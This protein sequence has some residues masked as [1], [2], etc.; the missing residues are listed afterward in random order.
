MGLLTRLLA[1]DDGGSTKGPLDDFWYKAVTGGTSSTGLPITP[2]VAMEVSAVFACVKVL[3]ETMGMLP[4]IVYER[5]GETS[6][7]RAVDDP[8][9]AL[10]HRAPNAWQTP[11]EFKENL[12]AWAALHGNGYALKVFGITGIVEELIPLHPTL[13]T[14]ELTATRTIRYQVRQPDGTKKPYTQGEMF[15]IRGLSLD[16][17]G[18]IAMSRQA[19]EAIGLARAMEAFGARYFANDTTI[20]MVIEHPG[21]LGPEAHTHLKES[22]SSNYGGVMNAWKPKVLE[23]GMKMNRIQAN[24]KDAQL[25]EGRLH[26]VIEICRFF[27][28]QPHKIAHL[29]QSTFSNI[30]HQ[31]IEHVTDTIQP[32]AVRWE[33]AVARDLILDDEKHFAEFDLRALIRGDMVAT[34]AYWESR[35]KLGSASPNQIRAAFGENPEPGGDRYYVNAATVP[36]DDEGLPIMPAKAPGAGSAPS[37][38]PADGAANAAR[39]FAPLMADAVDRIARAETRELEKRAGK[40]AEDFG[41]FAAWS[42]EYYT[43][44]LGYIEKTLAPVADAWAASTGCRVAVAALAAAM[45]DEGRMAVLS[46]AFRADPHSVIAARSPSIAARLFSAFS[47]E[48]AA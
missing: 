13:V 12:T 16:G 45:V 28:M 21:K 14:P 10:T 6:K 39:I 26:Q 32:W 18:G 8:V 22:F 36:L 37:N 3:G 7:Q 41:R 23:E 11:Y 48:R 29:I 5:T 1:G 46:P 2:D 4:L 43:A 15:H 40:A 44:H 35:F 42:D 17:V 19:R 25:I 47:L 24:G 9:Y 38:V 33:Q 27:R 31:A 30:E 34:S 20:G